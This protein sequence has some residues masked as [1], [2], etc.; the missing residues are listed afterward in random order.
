MYKMRIPMRERVVLCV[1]MA[2]GLFAS[3]V[4]IVRTTTFRRY[5]RVGDKLWYMND[6]AIWNLLEGQ[7]GIIAACIPYL[8]S[9]FERI[10]KRMG[11]LKE[12]DVPHGATSVR[13]SGYDYD[14]E[15]EA[16]RRRMEANAR[17]KDLLEL[18]VTDTSTPSDTPVNASTHSSAS[19][20]GASADLSPFPSRTPDQGE[21]PSSKKAERGSDKASEG[22]SGDQL[23]VK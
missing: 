7:L 22:S 19:S 12:D 21:S 2:L 13:V 15:M 5:K 3:A 20:D 11:V 17:R 1:L 9:T 18:S 8:K 4:V 10:L 6:I 16:I 23:P 14:K